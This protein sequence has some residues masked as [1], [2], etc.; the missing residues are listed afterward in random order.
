[1]DADEPVKI[2]WQD[3]MTFDMSEGL[4]VFQGQTTV[5]QGEDSLSCDRL[6]VG[7]SDGN[8]ELRSIEARGQVGMRDRLTGVVREVLSERLLW[9][10]RRG[11]IEL[12]AAEGETVTIR[13]GALSIA[14][15]RVVFDNA[16]QVLR[17]PE[18]GKLSVEPETADPAADT[19]A[20][21]TTVEWQGLME[22]R[23]SPRTVARF[24]GGAMARRAREMIKG[25]ELLAEFDEDM[26]LAR[27]TA[28]GGALVEVHSLAGEAARP[29]EEPPLP[30]IA[31]VEGERWRL[32]C[33]SVTLAPLQRMIRSGTPGSLTVLG[34]DAPSG[35]IGWSKSM[36]LDS[37][38]GYALFEG[39][40]QADVPGAELSSDELRLDFEQ[41]GQLHH[42]RAQGN[43]LF[44]SRGKDGWQM[45]SQSAQGVFA[46]GNVLR[47]FIARGE[48][49]IIDKSRA[50]YAERVQLFLEQLE[51]REQPVIDR[52]V[53]ERDVWVWYEQEERLEAG[54]DRLEWERE[55]D[56]YVLTGDPHAYVRRGNIRT[57]NWKVMLRRASGEMELPPGDRPVT[58]TVES[59]G[60]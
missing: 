6:D 25:E 9:D 20:D 28:T 14:A 56:T 55:T 4:A 46:A 7:F 8:R 29:G 39:D 1:M 37:A 31:G 35:T 13:S 43:V 45:S 53:A 30:D 40:I 24:R 23:Q 38:E 12:T 42:A 2:T 44:V 58:I 22:F 26:R 18:G 59:E 54:G 60:Q 34:A 48:V 50:L 15:A 47:Q 57:Q 3:S 10:A 16:Q 33:E 19:P 21:P 11:I 41:T 51:G 5:E 32:E 49:E 36:S 27:L 52:A 17:C